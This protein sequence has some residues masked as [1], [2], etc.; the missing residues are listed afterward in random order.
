MKLII[1]LPFLA[2]LCTSV[3]GQD[4]VTTSPKYYKVLL[5]NDQVRV[6]DYRLKAG[7]KEPIHSH[8]AGVVYV[9]SGAK[10][11][12]IYPDGRSVERPAAT[13]ET[14]WREPTT[15][16]VE[17]VGDT[18]AHAIAIDLKSAK[19]AERSKDEQTLWDLE[20]AYWRFVQDND[21]SSY[22][23]LW[24]ERFLGWPSVSATPVRKE[25]ITD[26]ITSQ[27]SKGLLFKTGELRP[28]SIEITGDVATVYYWISFNWVDKDGKG[29]AY[30]L[31]ITHAWL[32][33]A[34]DWRI[35]GGMSMPEPEATP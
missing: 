22:S 18:E 29:A 26:W 27:T 1:L 13:G 31:R 10:V 16:A 20:H 30:T 17:N 5:E 6:L 23:N 12:L 34:N 19:P 21:L 7:E 28:A 3:H 32:K 33:S 14:F 15:H 25:R 24:H 8:P 9:L 11:K 4:P 2:A 35:I